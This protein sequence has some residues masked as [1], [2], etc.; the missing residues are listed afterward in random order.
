MKS[1]LACI[2]QNYLLKKKLSRISRN[3]LKR[4]D[5]DIFGTM[6]PDKE[7]SG[8]FDDFFMV[9]DD[10]L[11]MVTDSVSENGIPISSFTAIAE[12]LIRKH[13]QSAFDQ[14]DL[15]D[16]L[17]VE[18]ADLITAWIGIMDLKSGELFYVSAGADQPVINQDGQIRFLEEGQEYALIEAENREF[19]EYCIRLNKGDKIFLYSDSAIKAVNADNE[20]YGKTRLLNCLRSLGPNVNCQETVSAVRTDIDRFVGAV[21]QIYD[22]TLLAF[23][24][25]SRIKE[26]KII[27]RIFDATTDKLHEV[28][29]FVEAELEKKDASMKAVTTIAVAL[30]EMFVNIAHYAY[31]EGPGKATIGVSFDGDDVIISLKDNGIYFDPLDKEDPDVT[32]RAEDREIGGLGIFMVKNSMDHCTYER[33]GNENYFEMRKKIR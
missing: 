13:V 27:E 20:F 26:I 9:D 22:L 12:N 7:T 21:A 33:R 32:A 2:L 23:D 25:T 17:K 14:D 8:D 29:D 24:F 6:S 18:T 31:P 11:V 1:G 19:K 15:G 28:I 30:E 10:H 4:D 5:F 3:F 16:Q